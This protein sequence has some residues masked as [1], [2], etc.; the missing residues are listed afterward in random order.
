MENCE[1]ALNNLDKSKPENEMTVFEKLLKKDKYIA[2][3]A[4]SDMMIAGIDTVS[5]FD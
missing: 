2:I 1:K 5:F 3:S 4:V